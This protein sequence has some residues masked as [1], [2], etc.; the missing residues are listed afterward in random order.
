M[1]MNN[2]YEIEFNEFVSKYNGEKDPRKQ[3]NIFQKYVEK[4]E[5]DK[6][7][8]VDFL[9]FLMSRSIDCVNRVYGENNVKI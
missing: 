6:T 1:K 9:V 8:F 4:Y 7:K 3:S 2:E 5:S